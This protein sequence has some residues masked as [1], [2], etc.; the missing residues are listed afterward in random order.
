MTRRR[1]AVLLLLS[2]FCMVQWVSHASAKRIALVVGNASYQ[3]LPA[4]RNTTNDA[5]AIA[6][7]L[8]YANFEVTKLL[9]ADLISMK[10]AFLAFGRAMRGD[11]EATFIFYAGHG[12][13]VDGENYLMPVDANVSYEDEVAIE[14]INANDFLRVLNGSRGAVNIVVLD[15]CRNNPFPTSLRTAAAGL[16]TVLA[17]RGTLI[18]YSTA[19]GSVAS[20]GGGENSDYTAALAE[21]MLMPGLEIAQVFRKVRGRVLEGTD[22]KQTPWESSSIIGEFYFIPQP[23]IASPPVEAA[24]SPYLEAATRWKELEAGTDIAALEAFAERYEGNLFGA[25]ARARLSQIGGQQQPQLSASEKKTALPLPPAPSHELRLDSPELNLAAL[26]PP[27]LSGTAQISG[28][29]SAPATALASSDFLAQI[30]FEKAERIS[31]A[32]GWQL[33]LAKHQSGPFSDSARAAL[34]LLEGGG[35]ELVSPQ[36]AE[37]RMKLTQSQRKEIQLTLSDLGYDIG[38]ADGN[39]GQ[40]TR[41]EIA[42]YQKALGLTETG[43]INR[44]LANRFELV[45]V[46]STDSVVSAD[47]ARL[48]DPEDLK[49][50]ETDERVIRAAQCLRG[51]EIIYGEF[52]SR[53]YVA[54]YDRDSSWQTAKS[55]AQ[56]C[57]AHLASITSKAEND[58]V[59]GLFEADDRIVETGFDG[60]VSYKIGP[61]IG[62]EQDPGGREPRGGWGWLSGE[63][64][65]YN[66]WLPNQPNDRKQG[67]DFAMFYGHLEGDRDTADLK[68]N[69][70]GDMGPQNSSHGYIIEFD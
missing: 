29:A 34:R 15:A 62:L 25:A 9:D 10:Q 46:S 20:D 36:G 27:A 7:S 52:G 55:A 49:G 70:W 13:Q 66:N 5:N 65:T 61:W 59:Y 39:F 40:K 26:P 38:A 35:D 41:R 19:P 54:V 33:Y 58:F 21:T 4:L 3:H 11:V 56:R 45:G 12:V 24:V 22:G 51:K 42:R 44:V 47:E 64:M 28:N 16:A 67:D 37:T 1:P 31:T 17:P 48:F 2:L 69:T 23:A 43:Y 30:D 32:R 14:G 50:L 57:D 8:E 53:L 68:A 60:N 63:A 18:A 6:R